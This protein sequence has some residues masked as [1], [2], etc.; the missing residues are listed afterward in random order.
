MGQV[1]TRE[2]SSVGL[3]HLPYK[4]RV[5]G[6]TPSAPTGKTPFYDVERRF[7]VKRIIVKKWHAIRV[8]YGRELKFQTLLNESGYETFVPMTVKA[9]ERDGKKERKTVPAVSNLCFVRADQQSLYDF[10]K[11]M[12]EASPARFIWDKATRNP[13]TIPDKAMEDFILVSRTMLDDVIYLNEVNS[14]LREG[15]KV[16]VIDGPFKGVEGKVVRIRKSRRVVIELPGMLAIAT[17]FIPKEFVEPIS[18]E[19]L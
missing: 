15:Q 7:I 4:Q 3:E 19:L 12:G 9:F 14:K 5:G 6:S 17:T 1:L 16:K 8:T 13:I 11:S 18:A 10:F 2:H